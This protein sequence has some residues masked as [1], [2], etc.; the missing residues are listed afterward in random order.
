LLNL[1]AGVSDDEDNDNDGR[2]PPLVYREDVCSG[3]EDEDDEGEDG[4]T[5]EEE[6]ADETPHYAHIVKFT[7]D[8]LLELGLLFVGYSERRLGRAKHAT[9][10]ECFKAHF[11]SIPKVC[12]DIWE[13]LQTT[14]NAR[15]WVPPSKRKKVNDFL[16]AFHH[17]LK[18]YP[19]EFERECI[20]DILLACGRE[21][22]KYFSRGK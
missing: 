4:I 17:H 22:V 9:N 18:R 5:E 2:I 15:A 21:C 3:D 8:E 19:T 1:D 20:F 6:A 13:D 11:G 12:C 10:I 16:M 7:V 14:K